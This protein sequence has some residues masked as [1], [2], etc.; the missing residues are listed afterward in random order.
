MR[1]LK[2]ALSLALAAAMLISLMVV[3]ASAAEYGD[4][5]QVSQTE[6]VEVLTGLGVVGGDQNGN[7]NPKATLTRAEYCVMIANAL[8][9]GT[10]D[11]TLFDGATTPFTDVNGHW[12]AEYI[13]Y[14]YSNGIVAGTSATTFSPDATLTAAQ[15]AA[16]LLMALGYNQNNEFALNGQFELN[17]TK[18]ARDAGLYNGLSVSATA[19]ISR[20]NT[21]RLIF[22]A[23]TNTTPVNYSSLAQSYYTVGTSAVSGVVLS[24]TQLDPTIGTSAER[25]NYTRTLGYTNFDLMKDSSAGKDDFG[26]PTSVWGV[27]EDH[28]NVLDEEIST[29]ANTPAATFTAETKAGDVANALRGYKVSD[30]TDEYNINNTTTYETGV[31]QITVNATITINTVNG[32][33]ATQKLVV[34]NQ[35][36]DETIAG[37]IA[38]ETANGRLVEIYADTN[39][40][41][42]FAVVVDYTV[43]E[44]TGVTSNATRTNYSFS[45]SVSGIDYVDENED[46]TIVIAGNIAKGDIV[47]ATKANGV[48][49]VYPTTTVTG[50][51]TSRTSD[52]KITVSGT[53]YALGTGVSG[54]NTAAFVNGDESA[55]YYVDQYGYVVETTSTASTDY[56][57]IVAHEAKLNTTFNEPDP[58]V[59]VRAV[60]ADGT[61]G[62]YDLAME[63]D[64]GTWSIKGLGTIATNNDSAFQSAVDTALDDGVYG[65]RLNDGVLTLEPLT[66]GNTSMQSGEV[67]TFF[68]NSFARNATSATSTGGSLTALL[69]NET[70]YVL[71]NGDDKA[72]TVYTGNA[73]LPSNFTL[74]NTTKHAIVTAD[75]NNIGTATVV[76]AAADVSTASTSEYVYIDADKYTTE[77]RDGDNVVVYD[78]IAADGSI[79]KVTNTSALTKDGIYGYNEDM[80]VI[81]TAR[82]DVTD[83]PNTF[84]DGKASPTAGTND[85]YYAYATGMELINN[86]LKVGSSYYNV[87]ADTQIIYVDDTLSTIDNSTGFVVLAEKDNAASTDVAVVYVTK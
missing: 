60:L 25:T 5:A 80:T 10:F 40:V 56:V 36:G 31:D 57:Y 66:F 55:N 61:V 76:F 16:I 72:A 65:Y 26:R 30:G 87:T 46:D 84:V 34:G 82:V 58:T 85:D 83:T 24:G 6:A 9:G 19:G 35:A 69:N 13:A 2:R 62:V 33:D 53:Q 23:L 1:N 75:G 68:I 32:S 67:Y 3:G 21:A 18:W 47:T 15:A 64:S 44:V 74:D 79:V 27:N 20:E 86:L 51:Q 38:K 41:V 70:I 11:R 50:V 42:N 63:V 49:Y 12:G 4:Q 52:N 59:Q 78:G 17:V 73:N 54:V 48:L 14:C 37:A 45:N 39:N 43:A 81:T 71:Y 29:V 77:W 28:N 22:N 8:T 7:F